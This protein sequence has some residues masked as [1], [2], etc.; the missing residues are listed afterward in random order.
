MVAMKY[1]EDLNVFSARFFYPLLG[2][3]VLTVTITVAASAL[4]FLLFSIGVPCLIDA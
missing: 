3:R 4:N 2:A 1:E